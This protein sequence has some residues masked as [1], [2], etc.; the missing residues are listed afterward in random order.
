MQDEPLRIV[1]RSQNLDRIAAQLRRTRNVGQ[2]PAVRAPEPQLAVRLSVE[3]VALLVDGAVVAATQKREV[4]E[5]R[6]ATIGPVLD[7]MA[8]AEGQSAP[9]KAATPVA[10]LQRAA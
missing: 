6:G 3:V 10:I 4:R 1:P 7:V 5:R 8:L 2:R 9:R